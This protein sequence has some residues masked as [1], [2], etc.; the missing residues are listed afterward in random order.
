MQVFMDVI[1]I[2]LFIK[3]IIP[4]KIFLIIHISYYFPIIAT[5]IHSFNLSWTLRFINPKIPRLQVF[6]IIQLHLNR[7][8]I[9]IDIHIL[10]FTRS[11]RFS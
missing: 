3:S 8:A 4:M 11:P 6:L 2:I 7:L 9:R 1:I 10:D 5:D